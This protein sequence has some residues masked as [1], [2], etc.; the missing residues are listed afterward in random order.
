MHKP[1]ITEDVA[2]K[3]FRSGARALENTDGLAGTG[4]EPDSD[5]RR[6]ACPFAIP[7]KLHTLALESGGIT[8]AGIPHLKLLKNLRVL[9]LDLT[10]VADAGVAELK[11]LPKLSALTIAFPGIS[12]AGLAHL[13]KITNLKQVELGERK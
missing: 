12:R 9:S 11:E 3:Y 10:S 8:D 7:A 6:G 1:D 4:A 2:R 13:D 5:H